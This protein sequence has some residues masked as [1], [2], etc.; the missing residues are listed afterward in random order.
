VYTVI[1][2]P[3]LLAGA[4]QAR[5]TPFGVRG[6]AVRLCGAPGTVR[7]V[8]LRAFDGDPVPAT[9]VARTVNE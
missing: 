3:P 1:A 6:A 4:D 9:L 8:A 2:E 7:G 5:F